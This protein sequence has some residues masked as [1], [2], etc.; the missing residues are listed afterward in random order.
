V[1]KSRRYREEVYGNP[2]ISKRSLI[3]DQKLEIK[4]LLDEGIK[5]KEIGSILSIKSKTLQRRMK[6]MEKE[7][8]I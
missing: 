4:A 6:E 7:G 3:E 2:N 8:L 1:N 5:K